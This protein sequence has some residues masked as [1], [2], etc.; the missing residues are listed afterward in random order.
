MLRTLVLVS[1]LGDK[2]QQMFG[3]V[4]GHQFDRRSRSGFG[5]DLCE[6]LWE[7][8]TCQC[9]KELCAF[10]LPSVESDRPQRLASSL[11][12]AQGTCPNCWAHARATVLD[13]H[14]CGSNFKVPHLELVNQLEKFYK[15]D[16]GIYNK[17]LAKNITGNDSNAEVCAKNARSF[18]SVATTTEGQ[19]NDF[20]CTLPIIKSVT[21]GKSPG[22]PTFETGSGRDEDC[23]EQK[24]GS[25]K[26]FVEAFNRGP[27]VISLDFCIFVDCDSNEERNHVMVL[28]GRIRR[29]NDSGWDLLIKNSHGPKFVKFKT[30]SNES[31]TFSQPVEGYIQCPYS[32]MLSHRADFTIFPHD[33]PSREPSVSSRPLPSLLHATMSGN[34]QLI[35]ELLE[36]SGERPSEDV[37]QVDSN[38]RTPL[39]WAASLGYVDVVELLLKHTV[40]G[41]APVDVNQKNNDWITP[42]MYAA[43]NGHVEVVKLLLKHGASAAK[44]ERNGYTAIDYAKCE[45]IRQLLRGGLLSRLLSDSLSWFVKGFGGVGGLLRYQ[46]D[47]QELADDDD[48]SDGE[49]I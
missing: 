25:A 17:A 20:I 33:A 5:T 40:D 45:S 4:V 13:A 29:K 23:S 26:R 14:E 34:H 22:E 8:Q 32:Q 47:F 30:P 42:L 1:A 31:S 27:A 3:V 49:W 7:L 11:P 37:N 48:S 16:L 38:G 35:G 18:Y 10:L 39:F 19:Q 24:L 46:V 43:A 6:M 44:Q 15:I 9:W 12:H 28:F 21:R 2:P 41:V 36:G